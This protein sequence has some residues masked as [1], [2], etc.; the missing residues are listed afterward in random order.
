MSEVH[1]NDLHNHLNKLHKDNQEIDETLD[2]D[3]YNSSNCCGAPFWNDTDICSDC[4]E[5]ADTA[6][7]DCEDKNECNN[8]NINY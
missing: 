8:E 5:H 3:L 7:T 4:K 6:C 2:C 1:D